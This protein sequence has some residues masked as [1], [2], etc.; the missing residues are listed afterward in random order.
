V[1]CEI[2]PPIYG[3]ILKYN[4]PYGTLVWLRPLDGFTE[5]EFKD[6]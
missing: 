1:D 4:R 6:L 5:K 2:I 3:N